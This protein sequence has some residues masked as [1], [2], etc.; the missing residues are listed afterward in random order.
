MWDLQ[1]ILDK[2][3][4]GDRDMVK[5]AADAID[6]GASC[7]QL[8]G[9]V[10]SDKTFFEEAKDIRR[11]T[12]ERGCA[13]IINDRIDI[14]A[15]SHADGVHLGQDDLP[16]IEARRL[17]GRSRIIGLSTHNIEEAIRAQAMGADYIGVGPIFA[18]KT[19]P[20]LEAIGLDIVSEVSKKI[21]MPILFIGGIS[22]ENINEIIERGARRVAVA[23]AILNCENITEATRSFIN[24][25]KGAKAAA[26]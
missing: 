24:L 5:I 8:R 1:V 26:T 23:S 12:K 21:E 4:V 17:F 20:I 13:L 16:Y 15:A 2:E 22:L 14:A 7:I 6:G 3:I 9:K 10:S 25:L 11:I 18:T 19:K